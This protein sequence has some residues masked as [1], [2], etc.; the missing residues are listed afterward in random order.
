[1]DKNLY[2]ILGPYRNL[3][4]LTIASLGLHDQIK[5]LNHFPDE[6]FYNKYKDLMLK[7]VK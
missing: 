2:L 1:M 7:F 3:T 4:T 5:I 6:I